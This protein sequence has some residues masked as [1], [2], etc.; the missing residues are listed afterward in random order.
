VRQS[1]ALESFVKK[2]KVALPL[3][4]SVKPLISSLPDAS[5]KDSKWMLIINERVE[6]DF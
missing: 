1:H 4:P 6:I 2:A 3:D 5:E